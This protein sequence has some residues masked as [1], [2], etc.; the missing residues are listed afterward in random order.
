VADVSEAIFS[1]VVLQDAFL[2]SDL[3]RTY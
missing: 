1:G 3:S 2:R